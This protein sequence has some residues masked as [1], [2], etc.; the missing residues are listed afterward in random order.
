MNVEHWVAVGGTVAGGVPTLLWMIQKGW[1]RIS[2]R[3]DMG[4]LPVE[5]PAPRK[6]PKRKSAD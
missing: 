5:A 3:V 6:K 1:L 4:Q 2:V